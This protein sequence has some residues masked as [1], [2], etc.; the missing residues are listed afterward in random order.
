[1]PSILPAFDKAA[2]DN[3]REMIQN[4]LLTE[5][6]RKKKADDQERENRKRAAMSGTA[7]A[8]AQKGSYTP[9]TFSGLPEGRFGTIKIR[10]SGKCEFL[11]G[12]HVFD[13]NT[14]S[15]CNFAQDVGSYVAGNSEFFFLGR[16]LRRMTVTPN[17][18]RLIGLARNTGGQ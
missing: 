1:M 2:M 11:I 8:A 5:D 10:Q 12:D 14:G 16:C 9:S 18:T 7:A 17:V 13:V 4:K 15:E 6:Q 3:Q